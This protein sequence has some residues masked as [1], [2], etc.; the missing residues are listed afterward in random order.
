MPT[1]KSNGVDE[2]LSLRRATSHDCTAGPSRNR[3]GCC[4]LGSVSPLRSIRGGRHP[5]AGS[6]SSTPSARS[7]GPSA[8]S[9][10]ISQPGCFRRPWEKPTAPQRLKPDRIRRRCRH[11]RA[12]HSLPRG[13]A[14]AF[15]NPGLDDHRSPITDHHSRRRHRATRCRSRPPA[16]HKHPNPCP[17]T[18]PHPR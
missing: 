14:E 8:R 6:I 15:P 1:R 18:T 4:T 7:N 2:E 3:C 12:G 9:R 10:K 11:L 13:C 5:C 16:I 17:T